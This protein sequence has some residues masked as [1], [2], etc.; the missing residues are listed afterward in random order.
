MKE[1]VIRNLSNV[2]IV[3]SVTENQGV[4]LITKGYC[5]KRSAR[6][7]IKNARSLSGPVRIVR[8]TA[9]IVLQSAKA[10]AHLEGPPIIDPGENGPPRGTMLIDH[11]MAKRKN[12]MK[13]I[14]RPANGEKGGRDN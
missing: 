14:K 7:A 9:R 2:S 8:Y 13:N 11:R 12:F 6:T 4:R 3:P 10:P 1:N 5:I